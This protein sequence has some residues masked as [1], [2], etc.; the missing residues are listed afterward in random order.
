[1]RYR[2]WFLNVAYLHRLTL[3]HKNRDVEIKILSEQEKFTKAYEGKIVEKW[4]Q[5]QARLLDESRIKL[6]CW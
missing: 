3:N 5:D 6:G 4:K 1:M 2:E